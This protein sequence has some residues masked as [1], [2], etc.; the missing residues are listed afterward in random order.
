[1][2][3]PSY[4]QQ[5]ELCAKSVTLI[6]KLNGCDFL[7]GNSVLFHKQQEQVGTFCSNQLFEIQ[8]KNHH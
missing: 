3:I 8:K 5:T 1:M 4:S 6:S 2:A 7:W